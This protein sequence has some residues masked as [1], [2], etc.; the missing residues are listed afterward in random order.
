MVDP[1]P[2]R[3]ERC[4]GS[5]RYLILLIGFVTLAAAS[6]VSTSFA[7]FYSTL[8]KEFDWSHAEGASVYSVNMLVLAAGAPFMGWALDRFG[9]RGL[10]P[11]AA[12]LIGGAWIA[13]STLHT[14]GQFVLFYG[15]VSALGQTALPLMAVV[16]SGWF[17]QRQRG[18]AIGLTDVGT[19]FGHVLFVPGSAWVI[20]TFGWRAAFAVVGIAVVALLVPLNLL[21][22]PAPTAG[23]PAHRAFTFRGALRSRALWM[24]C[25]AHLCM[26]V[27]MTM[28]NVHLVEFLVSTGTLQ[29]LGA[30]TIFSAVSL[31]SLGGRVFFGWLAD[32]LKGEGAFSVAMSCTMTGYV[33]L[34]L[35][36]MRG[37]RWPLYAF[38]LTYGFA[39]G[40]GGIA[41]AA[42]TVEVFQGPHLGTIFMVV[43]LS[44]S[45]GA[46]FGA[47]FGGRL[48]DLSG[49]YLLTF[50]TALASG[51]VA[52]ACMWAGRGGIP[53]RPASLPLQMRPVDD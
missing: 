16:V 10:F 14:L 36:D 8:L 32:R 35:L 20:A 7:V 3:S 47:W 50:A 48:F 40:A 45:L 52:I 38:V 37:A 51:A 17:E 11:T 15:V 42:K 13:C 12:A 22:R 4:P 28:V 41:I 53:R 43:T 39:Q 25:V 27:T 21:H 34:L 24:L 18:R 49:S 44:H 29:L 5:Y 6:G 1:Y 30:S 9:P 23:R 2:P 19:G 46:A 26:S 31:V 33:L